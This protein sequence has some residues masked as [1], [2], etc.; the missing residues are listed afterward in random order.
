MNAPDSTPTVGGRFP[1]A[2]LPLDN[3]YARLPE[4]FHTRLP[5]RPLPDPHLVCVS[6]ETAALIGL[7]PAVIDDP[8]FVEIFAGN[9]LLPG[10]EPLAA[11]YSGHQFGEWAGQL[12]DGRA[13]LLAEVRTPAGGLELQLKGSG[14]TPYSRFGDGRA[15][16]RSSIREFLCSEAMAALGIPT[17]RALCVIGSPATVQR[18]TVETAA[19]VTRVAESFVRFGS[20]EHWGFSGRATELRQLAD[21][22]IDRFRPELRD[23]PR[24][25]ESLLVDVARRTAVLI[26]QWQ[27][28]GF[29]HGV[30]N[31]DNMSILGLTLDYGPFGFMEA[32]D[33]GAVCNHS[34]HYGR[35]AY[36]EQPRVALW[37]LHALGM[38]MQPLIGDPATIHA[39]V[40]EAFVGACTA[41]FVDRMRARLGFATP[42]SDDA[43][44]IDDTFALLQRGRV[45]YTHFFRRL[46]SLP[47]RVDE[48]NAAA[49]DAP[50][51]DLFVDREDG[52]AWL[53]RWRGRLAREGSIDAVRQPAMRAVNPKYILRNW[54]AEHAIRAARQGRFDETAVVLNCL[55]RPFDEQPSCEW[56]ASA[57]PDWAAT[58]SV[59]CSS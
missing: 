54:V 1:L 23:A 11:V 44:F 55:Q 35:Y 51:R 13:H 26:A 25:Y 12:G 32:F 48:D 45:D 46:S 59:S 47:G 5:P 28:I 9:A 3:S 41:A 22:V 31:T 7:H 8:A 20:F 24:P 37:N 58:L 10:A 57:P 19:V 53:R 43:G 17:T 39:I 14:R 50:M 6:A 21:Y 52:D 27:A 40:D 15:V 33:G 38:A 34:D 4:I 29:M 18:E 49:I 16:L 2:G 42:Q 56:L 30:M 36:G